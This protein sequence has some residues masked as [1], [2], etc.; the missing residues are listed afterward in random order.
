MTVWQL[1][2]SCVS[3]QDKPIPERGSSFVGTILRT[4]AVKEK[5]WSVCGEINAAPDSG[6]LITKGI[7]F[8][9]FG[10]E[11]VFSSAFLLR[12]YLLYLGNF[13]CEPP[14]ILFPQPVVDL[15]DQSAVVLANQQPFSV[16]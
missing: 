12:C 16:C 11:S 13:S 5:P 4:A 6:A 1:S 10:S 2:P 7:S 8:P 14:S 15:G 9:Y 3:D